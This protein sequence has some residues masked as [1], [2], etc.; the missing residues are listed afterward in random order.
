MVTLR[1]LLCLLLRLQWLT[2][3]QSLFLLLLVVV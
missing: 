2:W 3:G 1:G